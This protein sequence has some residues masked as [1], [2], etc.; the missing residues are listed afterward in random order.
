MQ[1][2]AIAGRVDPYRYGSTRR[3][4]SWIALG[5][6]LGSWLLGATARAETLVLSPEQTQIRF[7]LDSTLHRVEGTARLLSG[8]IR[9]SPEGG[10]AQGSLVVDARSVETG[11]GMRDGTLHEKVLESERFPRIELVPETLEIGA[12][13]G[14]VWQVVLE[15]TTRIHGGTWPLSIPAEVTLEHGVAH[16]RG[17]FVIP[18][19]AWGMRDMSNF[20]LHVEKQVHVEFDA[21]GRIVSDSAASPSDP[22]SAAGAP[23]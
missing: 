12:H 22:S 18:H 2:R 5:L 8:E 13:E 17:K 3:R 11:N 20:L 15:G 23:G 10:A 21:T 16:V 7:E 9:F 4:I 14:A 6:G 19:V 1:N